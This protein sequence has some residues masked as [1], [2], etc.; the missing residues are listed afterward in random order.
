M[1]SFLLKILL[2]ACAFIILVQLPKLIVPEFWGNPI[3]DGKL[4][5]LQ[6][7]PKYN[8]LFIGSSRVNNQIDP[9]IFDE[10]FKRSKSFNLGASGSGSYETIK[11][12]N[13]LLDNANKLGVERIL[14]EFVTFQNQTPEKHAYSTRGSYFIGFKYWSQVCTMILGSS[15]PVH[16]KISKLSSETFLLLRSLTGISNFKPAIQYLLDSS[17]PNFKK[18]RKHKGYFGLKIKNESAGRKKLLD[19]PEAQK[20][21][22][23]QTKTL[24]ESW[25]MT[26]DLDKVGR[27]KKDLLL[28]LIAKAKKRNIQLYFVLFP[29]GKTQTYTGQLPI[30]MNLPVDHRID[31]ANPN[32]EAKELYNFKYIYDQVHLT[33]QGSKLMTKKIAQK[34]RRKQ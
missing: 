33:D 3:I 29:N 31:I 23:N 12:L 1:R 27:D 26:E 10:H 14:C 6:E 32:T 15:N 25:N 5:Y 9:E 17:E 18:Y 4:Q 22:T 8:T 20:K 7:N 21:K 19:N 2:I 30:F 11:L 13:Y 16:K 34:A 24:F 28:N